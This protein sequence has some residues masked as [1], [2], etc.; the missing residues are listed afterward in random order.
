MALFGKTA[1]QRR[2]ENPKTKGNIRDFAN[3]AQLV[4]LVNLENLNALFIKEN[5]DQEDR[6]IKLNQ[7]AIEQMKLL[8][9]DT[10]K[11]LTGK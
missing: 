7:I 9:E 4:C 5:I 8:S 2:E 11:K 3:V 10:T 1:K 6:L